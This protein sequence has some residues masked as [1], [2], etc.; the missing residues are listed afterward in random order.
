MASLRLLY[1]IF[2]YFILKILYLSGLGPVWVQLQLGFIRPTH[3]WVKTFL[4][5]TSTFIP[6]FYDTRQKAAADH[7]EKQWRWQW[8]R[9]M[10][11]TTACLS[12]KISG[13]QFCLIRRLDGK[14]GGY[15]FIGN[16]RTPAIYWQQ[17][18]WLA[19][20]LLEL[21]WFCCPAFTLFCRVHW[22]FLLG[23]FFRT[24]FWPVCVCVCTF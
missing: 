22:T 10:A 12:C 2:V 23:S 13:A 21:R 18:R 8:S 9:T 16:A 17:Q 1:C 7:F 24:L 19:A 6:P 5:P 3:V 4:S 15:C 20:Y 11:M 14:T